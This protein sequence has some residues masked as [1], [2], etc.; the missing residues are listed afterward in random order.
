MSARDRSHDERVPEGLK[1]SSSTESS[2]TLR[3]GQ[4]AVPE[5][6]HSDL[7]VGKVIFHGWNFSPVDLAIGQDRRKR[8]PGTF[9][10]TIG[11]YSLFD[12]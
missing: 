11:L 4:R 2:L 3:S 9:M 6:S 8:G 10:F 1:K 12:Q 5:S 7:A